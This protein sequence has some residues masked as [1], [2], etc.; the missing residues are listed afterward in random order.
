MKTAIGKIFCFLTIL[1]LS[2]NALY[3]FSYVNNKSNNQLSINSDLLND[4]SDDY[5]LSNELT[6]VF[7][8][9]LEEDSIEDDT[10]EDVEFIFDFPDSLLFYLGNSNQQ[11]KDKHAYTEFNEIGNNIPLWLWVKHILI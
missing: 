1:L 7:D 4:D 5:N 11:S 6:H 8:F 3:S 2:S 9:L 10:F